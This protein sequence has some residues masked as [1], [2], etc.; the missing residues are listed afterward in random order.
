MCPTVSCL[1][2]ASVFPVIVKCCIPIISTDSQSDGR[3]PFIRDTIA[4]EN[5]LRPTENKKGTK[6]KQT[7]SKCRTL[8]R[9]KDCKIFYSSVT[10]VQHGD[11]I[12]DVSIMY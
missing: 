1:A 11:T 10:R 12:Q 5:L 8:F 4:L 9:T 7:T 2:F 6:G 3:I